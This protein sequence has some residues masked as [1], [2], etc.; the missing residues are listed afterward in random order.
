MEILHQVRIPQE[1]NR[2]E[3]Q[4][5]IMEYLLE[6]VGKAVVEAVDKLNEEEEVL[7]PILV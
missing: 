1:V 5:Q 3:T 6:E 2:A 4:E 7:H